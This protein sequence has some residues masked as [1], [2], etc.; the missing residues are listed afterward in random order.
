MNVRTEAVAWSNVGDEVVLMLMAE[1]EYLSLNP[2]GAH[3]W[4]RLVEGATVEE[5][6]E[7]L[8]D[9]FEVEEPTARADVDAFIAELRGRGLLDG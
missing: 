5:L 7:S 9:A 2:S 4:N 8:D 6:V 3:L 1:S